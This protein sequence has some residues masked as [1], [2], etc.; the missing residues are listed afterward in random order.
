MGA[1]W[2]PAGVFEQVRSVAQAE[3]LGAGKGGTPKGAPGTPRPPP[4]LAPLWPPGA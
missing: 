1:G 2:G 4:L 3:G